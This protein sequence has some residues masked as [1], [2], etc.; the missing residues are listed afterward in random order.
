M[1]VKI[2]TLAVECCIMLQSTLWGMFRAQGTERLK[3]EPE[4]YL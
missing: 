3:L 2:Q 1:R 4:P